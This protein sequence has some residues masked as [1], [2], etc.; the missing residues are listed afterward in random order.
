MLPILA[1]GNTRGNKKFAI[2]QLIIFSCLLFIGQLIGVYILL[3][4]GWWMPTVPSL[5][6]IILSSSLSLAS[7]NQELSKF[8]YIDA[9]TRIP[10]RRAYEEHFNKNRRQGRQVGL[11]ICDVDFF[12]GYN[13]TYGHQAG[14]ICLQRVAHAIFSS[15]RRKDL[16]A[17]YG[18]EEF[19]VLVHDA[20]EDIVLEVA[21]RMREQVQK[22]KLEH[23]ASKVCPHVTISCGAFSFQDD[24]KS[25][26]KELLEIAD[27]GLY[28]A[29]ESGRNRVC[30]FN[31]KN[32]R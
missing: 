26:L 13:D 7:S 8:A 12:K 16:A 23:K 2:I 6:G 29:K 19:V 22:M 4:R 32:N 18:G 10:N 30:Q 1:F 21:E 31:P 17:R 20:S 9:L 24:G 15:V 5:V 14:D 27:K 3:L 11:I 28:Q 25:P